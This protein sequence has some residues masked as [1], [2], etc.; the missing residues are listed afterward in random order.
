MGK[1]EDLFRI[2][3]REINPKYIQIALAEIDDLEYRQTI[4]EITKE[5]QE[6]K[7]RVLVKEKL[8]L[9]NI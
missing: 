1:K 2:K 6:K 5:K 8:N 3:K 9:P 4:A 7:R